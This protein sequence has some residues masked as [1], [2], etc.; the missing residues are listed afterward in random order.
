[1]TARNQRIVTTLLGL[2]LGLL[3][4][5]ASGSTLAGVSPGARERAPLTRGCRDQTNQDLKDANLPFGL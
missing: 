4:L 2:V 3:P 5:A 1:M